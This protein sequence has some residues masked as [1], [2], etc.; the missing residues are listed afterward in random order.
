MSR[1]ILTAGTTILHQPTIRCRL[2]PRPIAPTRIGPE[3]I[4]RRVIRVATGPA[5]DLPVAD[6]VGA[7][8][9]AA[10]TRVRLVR[11]GLL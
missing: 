2:T 7:T 3:L 9:G 10:L 11:R 8:F 6:F 5:T 1:Q 4:T